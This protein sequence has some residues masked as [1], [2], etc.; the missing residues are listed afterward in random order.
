MVPA[1]SK[2]GGLLDRLSDGWLQKKAVLS[3]VYLNM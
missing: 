2:A 3:G 1:S